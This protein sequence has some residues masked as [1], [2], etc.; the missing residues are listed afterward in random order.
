VA[1]MLRFSSDNP[2]LVD[3]NGTNAFLSAGHVLAGCGPHSFSIL[4]G[5]LLR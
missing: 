2:N 1:R 3:S 5:P 4:V